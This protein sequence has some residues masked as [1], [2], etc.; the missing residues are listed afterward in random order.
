MKELREDG[1]VGILGGPTASGKSALGVL[2]AERHG[3]A[4]VS[5]DSMQ[6][7]RG[8]VIGT[9]AIAVQEQRGVPHHL[10][11]FAD[12]ADNFEAA[13]FVSA[14]RAAAREEW[15]RYGR[16]TLV[17]GGTGMWIQALR[18]G[19]FPGPGRDEVLRERLRGELVSDG[20]E[21][22]HRRL[23]QVD[24]ATAGRL[25][26]RDHVRVLRALEVHELTGKP[27]SAWL[28]EDVARRR[29]IGTLLPLYVMAWPREVLRERIAARVDAMLAAGWPDE[30]RRVA[31]LRLPPHLPAGKAIGYRQ[32]AGLA[33]GEPVP[34]AI[35]EEIIL[36]TYQYAKRQLTWFRAQREVV[37]DPAP[38]LEKAERAFSL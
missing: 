35:R 13:R 27:L 23:A 11:G 20:A 18:E 8:M 31:E 3:L 9:G 21:A 33:P 2:L 19:L 14:A 12:P 22:M 17:V 15:Q 36:A 10:L 7:Y 1:F 4:V 16:R 24:P 29:A 25:S 30:A 37:L 32:L 28:E 6:V 34:S 38:T 26:P 5:A